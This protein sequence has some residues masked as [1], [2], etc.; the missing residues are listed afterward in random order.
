MRISATA[1]ASPAPAVFTHSGGINF[2]TNSVNLGQNPGGSGAYFL[3]GSGN[4]QLFTQNLFVGNNGTGTFTQTGGTNT[5]SN[6]LTLAANLGSSGTYN[7]S[8]GS[9]GAATV[10]LNAGGVFNQT[11]GIFDFTTFN[12]SG[13]SG[14]L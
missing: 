12:H 1:A 9:L 8:G 10:N 13:G 11:G 4:P 2:V 6:Y 7:L 3:G 5:V 14:S